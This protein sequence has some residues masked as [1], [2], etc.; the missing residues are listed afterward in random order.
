MSDQA[1]LPRHNTP[2]R[3][4]C[5]KQIRRIL[6]TE[7]LQQGSNRHFKSA[8]DFMKYFE[9]LYPASG[10]LTKQV[11]RAIKSMDMPRDS[12]GFFIID[13]TKPQMSQDL[14]ISDIMERADARQVDIEG[15][16]LLFLE[17][18]PTYQDYL[19]LLVRQSR[20]LAGKY[21]TVF[22]SS[23]GLVFL[24]TNK[25]GLSAILKHLRDLG[26]AD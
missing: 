21:I 20:T 26:N 23:R 7:V 6:M 17:A 10:A 3:A 9:S 16:E 25:N 13:K 8:K 2:S 11:Q 22:P 1:I 14:E 5:E 12:H 15:A 24:T 4:E 19:M 18:D